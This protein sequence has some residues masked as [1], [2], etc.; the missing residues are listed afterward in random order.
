MP[1]ASSVDRITPKQL[2]ANQTLGLDRRQ[3]NMAELILTEFALAGLPTRIAMA[4]VA[5]AYGESKL[6]PNAVAGFL[7]WT[8]AGFSPRP[9]GENSVG[10]FQLNAARNAAGEGMSV[11][12]RKNPYTHTARIILVTKS[13]LPKV[14]VGRSAYTATGNFTRWVEDPADPTPKAAERMLYCDRI[15]G[16][17]MSRRDMAGMPEIQVTA[18][19]KVDRGVQM[20]VPLGWWGLAG[21]AG[22]LVV[23]TV[24]VGRG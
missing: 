1:G 17:A 8:G 6:D 11:R 3:L 4:A 18:L 22:A 5:N 2:L 15:F 24:M 10:L 23:A 9:G 12:D 16:S 20:N 13:V 19:A 7:P 21:V 14:A